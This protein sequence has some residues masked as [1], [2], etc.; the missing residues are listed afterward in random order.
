VKK[1]R[2]DKVAEAVGMGV[3]NGSEVSVEG[4]EAHGLHDVRG[5]GGELGEGES[6]ESGRTCGAGGDFEKI[7]RPGESDGFSGQFFPEKFTLGGDGDAKRGSGEPLETLLFAQGEFGR[8]EQR[9][10]A[11]QP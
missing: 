6:D 8:K 11:G 4:G 3:G 10:G 7:S 9:A 2:S 1:Q 5:I